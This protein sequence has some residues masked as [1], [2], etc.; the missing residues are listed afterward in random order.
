MISTG[1]SRFPVAWMVRASGGKLVRG[2]AGGDFTGLSNDTRTIPR[3]ALYVALRGE[4][5]DGHKFCREAL[6][7]GAGGVLVERDRARALRLPG[8]AVVIEAANTLRA[9]GRIAREHRRRFD[10]PVIA[11][12][13]SNG[14]TTTKEMAAAVIGRRFRIL[15]TEGNLNNLIGLPLTLMGL[16]PAHEVAVLELGMNHSGEIRDLTRICEP[17]VGVITNVGPA[18]IENFRSLDGIGRAKGELYRTM[19]GGT[20]VVNADDPRAVEQARGLRLKRITFGIDRPARLRAERIRRK[21]TTSLSF[22]LVA[23]GKRTRILLPAPGRYNVSNALAAAGAAHAIGLGAPD[24]ARGLAGFE[25]SK[26]RMEIVKVGRNVILINDCYNANPASMEAALRSFVEMKG[27]ARGIAVLGDMLELGKKSEAAHRGV[28]KLVRDLGLEVLMT[29]GRQA[30]AI[31]EEASGRGSPTEVHIGRSHGEIASK[32][33]GMVQG[34]DWV[35]VKGSRGMKMEKI[36]EG[37]GT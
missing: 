30:R 24:V 19:R 11:I 4:R 8:G 28:G 37:F 20:I 6:T 1:T 27:D 17:T 13:G 5:F 26:W 35:L 22:T 18:H 32:L 10:I 16:G 23:G 9:L 21:D 14:K 34:R 31:A 36:V 3:G 29:Y 15:K 7:K 12:T 25:N 33:R 2:S